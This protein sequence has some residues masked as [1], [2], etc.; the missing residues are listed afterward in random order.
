MTSMVYVRE[1][2]I[3]DDFRQPVDG[4]WQFVGLIKMAMEMLS[5]EGDGLFYCERDLERHELIVCFDEVS[6]S[7]TEVQ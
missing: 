3:D 5:G 2:D 7:C 4:S 6:G 1:S